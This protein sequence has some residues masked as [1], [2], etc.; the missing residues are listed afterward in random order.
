MFKQNLVITAIVTAIILCGI[1]TYNY[2]TTDQ[3]ISPVTYVSGKSVAEIEKN[4]PI[5]FEGMTG[6]G[7]ERYSYFEKDSIAKRIFDFKDGVCNREVIIPKDNEAIEQ[8]LH[9]FNKEAQ[10]FI[11]GGMG[12]VTSGAPTIAIIV[13]GQWRIG[14]TNIF[15]VSGEV[16]E[17][18]K[19]KPVY[20]LNTSSVL[21]YWAEQK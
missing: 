6:D 18:G 14:K 20:F 10:P 17:N 21:P 13:Q 11:S 2:F 12:T 3:N 16:M 7:M 19:A 5:T 4:Y 1:Y 15:M 8:Y 9:Y